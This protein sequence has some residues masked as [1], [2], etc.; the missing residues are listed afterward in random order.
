MTKNSATRFYPKILRHREFWRAQIKHY[1]MKYIVEYKN[2]L[3]GGV[4]L[5]T[6]RVWS[7][8]ESW[9][10][11][12]VSC[13]ILAQPPSVNSGTLF[14]AGVLGWLVR[15]WLL[16]VLQRN[17]PQSLPPSSYPW[18]PKKEW[19]LLVIDDPLLEYCRYGYK[20]YIIAT[21]WRLLYSVP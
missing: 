16:L 17:H 10:M 12:A 11:S 5:Y 18:V 6:V 20:A 1:W 8:S 9:V 19:A 2:N 4:R 3:C 14:T 15:I 21:K 7:Y 13:K